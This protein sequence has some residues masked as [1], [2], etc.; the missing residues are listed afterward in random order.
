MEQIA[1]PSGNTWDSSRT[2]P[3]KAS[4]PLGS[5]AVLRHDMQLRTGR[6]AALKSLRDRC[7]RA[8]PLPNQPTPAMPFTFLC[9]PRG[10]RLVDSQNW[11]AVSWW[12]AV[13]TYCIPCADGIENR[14]YLV[15]P[16]GGGGFLRLG[17]TAGA[18]GLHALRAGRGAG[19]RPEDARGSR[20]RNG[21]ALGHPL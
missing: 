6:A 1:P 17:R 2:L 10:G 8:W 11:V 18:V 19:G 12:L 15:V 13:L 5:L 20:C 7:H 16:A 4:H 3:L 14:G 21:S 9:A